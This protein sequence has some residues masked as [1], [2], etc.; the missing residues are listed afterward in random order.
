MTIT[1]ALAY[2]LRQQW[3]YSFEKWSRNTRGRGTDN[4]P[5]NVTEGA[6]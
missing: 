4:F 2:L 3:L 5:S 1:E 6:D